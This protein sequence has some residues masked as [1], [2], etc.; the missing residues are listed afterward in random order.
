MSNVVVLSYEEVSMFYAWILIQLEVHIY[1][2]S[3]WLA[4]IKQFVHLDC[5][6]VVKHLTGVSLILEYILLNNFGV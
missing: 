6:F 1:E 5:M 3:L 4:L 2:F